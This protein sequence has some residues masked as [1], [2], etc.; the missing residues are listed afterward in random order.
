MQNSYEIM[1][2]KTLTED[3]KTGILFFF[4]TTMNNQK[5]IKATLKYLEHVMLP[6][7]YIMCYY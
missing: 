2:E 1:L 6:S 5:E 7:L 4:W 3:F